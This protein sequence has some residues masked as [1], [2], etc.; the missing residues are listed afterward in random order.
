[1]R[2]ASWRF[3]AAKEED[4]KES[5]GSTDGII[6]RERRR[7]CTAMSE[8]VVTLRGLGESCESVE[9]E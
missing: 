1:V 5:D 7:L 4:L 8:S 2:F 3:N 6:C 9:H